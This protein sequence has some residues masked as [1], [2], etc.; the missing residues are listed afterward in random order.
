MIEEEQTHRN[1][2]RRDRENRCF[3]TFPNTTEAMKMEEA[4][5]GAGLL[6]RLVPVP[7]EIT[8]GCGLGWRMLPEDWQAWQSQLNDAGYDAATPVEQ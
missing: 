1:F 3:M 2:L 8:A 5:H 4:C 7:G 6:G